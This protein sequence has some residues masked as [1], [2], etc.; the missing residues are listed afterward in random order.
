MKIC[1]I[2]QNLQDTK[3][4]ENESTDNQFQ[5]KKNIEE[6]DVKTLLNII[7]DNKY[8]IKLSNLKL[9]QLMNF[10]TEKKK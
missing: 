7:K 8:I 9:I 6:F 4:L 10:V 5:I 3:I 1:H 2:L